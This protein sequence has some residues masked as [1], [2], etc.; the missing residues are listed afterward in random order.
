MRLLRSLHIMVLPNLYLLR[1]MLTVEFQFHRM[2]KTHYGVA[3]GVNEEDFAVDK[4][5][6][7]Y[8]IHGKRVELGLFLKVLFQVTQ[9]GLEKQFRDEGF[10]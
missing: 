8:D 4:L 5:Y 2:C 9:E 7:L 6:C 1:N 10:L 3:F